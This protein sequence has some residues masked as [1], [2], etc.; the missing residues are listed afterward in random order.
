LSGETSG[1]HERER[2]G[3]QSGGE[4]APVSHQMSIG[5][6]FEERQAMRTPKMV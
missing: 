4:N 2:G 5:P 6:A 3:Q 1:P